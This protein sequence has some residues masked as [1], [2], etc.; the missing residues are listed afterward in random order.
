MLSELYENLPEVGDLDKP[1]MIFFFDEAHLLFDDAP[2]ALVD[3]VE[4]VVRLIR[5]KGVGVYFISQKPDDIPED[6][7]AQLGNR[8]QHALRAY[9]PKE[10]KAIKAAAESFR[11]NP[12]FDTKT[13]I[14]ELGVGEAL[15]S[16]LD[17]NGVPTIVEQ[18]KILPPQSA[19]SVASDED[20]QSAILSSPFN[21]KYSAAV[22]RESA[23]E[24]L[25]GEAQ[26]AEE[27][28]AQEEAAKAEAKAQAE[29]AKAQ[30]EA[31][32]AQAQAAKAQAKAEAEAAK[33]Q[34]KAQ[35]AQAK[36]QKTVQEE[37]VDKAI[38]TAT[39]QIGR[40]IGKSISRG[41]LG[42]MKLF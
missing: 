28:K 10:Q 18:A 41:I 22:D 23:Y 24:I 3:K 9:T 13:V 34:A 37:L 19:M 6:V 1:K 2:K 25:S 32:K 14:Q 30:A 29:V 31:A 27:A 16:F 39:S 5:S 35:K 8:I 12:D 33:A 7:L 17:E 36:K 11:A 15:V 26:A 40:E 21:A 38:K 4:Q 20:V 42:G